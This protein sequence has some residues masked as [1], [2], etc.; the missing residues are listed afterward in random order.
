M[1]FAIPPIGLNG[2]TIRNNNFILRIK[3]PQLQKLGLTTSIFNSLQAK[4][5]SRAANPNNSVPKYPIN[6]LNLYQG[7]QGQQEEQQQ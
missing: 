7:R 2:F 1:G 6:K 4:R 5:Q 3:N